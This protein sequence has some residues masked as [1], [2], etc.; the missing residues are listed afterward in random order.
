MSQRSLL[1]AMNEQKEEAKE[2]CSED[3]FEERF[4]DPKEG[5]S[6]FSE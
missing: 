2:W 6:S 1:D 3:A 5:Q 4:D